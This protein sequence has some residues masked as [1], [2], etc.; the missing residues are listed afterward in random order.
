MSLL[1]CVHY[2][3]QTSQGFDER[4]LQLLAGELVRMI[5]HLRHKDAPWRVLVYAL[6]CVEV[7]RL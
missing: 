5:A 1:R 2:L 7:Y 4:I 6:Q 3:Q